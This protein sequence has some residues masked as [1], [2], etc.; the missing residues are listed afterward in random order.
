MND[1]RQYKGI[2]YSYYL[3][4]YGVGH[5]KGGHSGRYPWGSGN[6]PKQ[7][8]EDWRRNANSS[9]NSING[10]PKVKKLTN[11]ER[12]AIIKDALKSIRFIPTKQQNYERNKYMT[13]VPRTEAQCR[14]LGWDNG[15]ASDCHQFTS[16]DKS[17]TKWVSPDGRSEVIFDK[18]GKVVTSSEDY[19]TFNYSSPN[20]DPLGHFM[21]DVIPWLAWG[22]SPDD[23]T[24]VAD[25]LGAFFVDGT[26]S[27]GKKVFHVKKGAA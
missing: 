22:N 26:F 16:K 3:S 4:H 2:D 10:F 8:F 23:S 7:A 11:E 25:R 14:K 9:K 19:G 21:K 5:D 15:V 24:S 6:R 13:N 18:N 27:I 1:F 12:E 20:N 17:N